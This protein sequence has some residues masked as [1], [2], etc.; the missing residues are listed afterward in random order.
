MFKYSL[1]SI[2]FLIAFVLSTSVYAQDR[3][4]LRE[5]KSMHFIVYYDQ[6]V[7]RSFID[8]LINKS[9]EAYR[10]IAKDLNFFRDEPWVFDRRAK[11]FVYKDRQEYLDKTKMPAWSYGAANV[12]QK[13]VYTFDGA[14]KVFKY[15][16]VHE[17]TH[18]IFQEFIGDDGSIPLWLNEGAAMYME[19]KGH[20]GQ[21]VT[22]VKKLTKNEYI[23]MKELLNI[24]FSDIEHVS[25]PNGEL[26][27]NGY[28]GV[29]YLESFS[30]I[31]FLIKKYGRFRFS[32]FCREI[33]KGKK[34]EEALFK[35]YNSLRDYEKLEE[36]WRRF[37]G[38]GF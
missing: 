2:L 13:E 21:L 9:E 4:E 25:N 5:R 32:M 10:Q 29:F 3:G 27:G 22:R 23:P 8:K 15:T 14:W 1:K 34:P 37:Y 36:Q 28:V 17:L 19:H 11:I 38:V 33:S 31:N 18:L 30:V 12:R 24:R 26:Q 6:K 35:S 7:D 20:R 16:L